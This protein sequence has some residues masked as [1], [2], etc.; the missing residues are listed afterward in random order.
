MGTAE[1]NP[2][3]GTEVRAKKR[4]ASLF[5]FVDTEVGLRDRKVHDIGAVRYDGAVYHGASKGELMKFLDKIDYLC[6]HNIIRHDAKYLFGDGQQKWQFVDTLF[7]SPLLFPERPYHKLLKD[8]KL[9]TEELNNPVNDCQKARDLLMDEV[10]A[11]RRLPQ[12]KQTIYAALLRDKTE[13]SGFVEFVE[14]KGTDDLTDET[15]SELIRKN[16]KGKI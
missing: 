16:F 5:A 11:W 6:G 3:Q 15:L 12:E 8:E 2:P 14:D 13:F 7:V 4:D 10:T 1:V 9:Q